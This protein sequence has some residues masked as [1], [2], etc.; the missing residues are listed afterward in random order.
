MGMPIAS[1][2]KGM[3]TADTA[4]GQAAYVEIPVRFDFDSLAPR[5]SAAVNRLHTAAITDLG[6]AGV[7][8]GLIELIRLRASQ[9][10]GC[11]YCVDTHTVDART[12]G[13]DAQR[14]DL[15][16]VW[17][18]APVYTE[19]ERAALALTESVTRLSQ[20][21]VPEPVVTRALK[22]LGEAATAAILGLI[23][24]IN[25]WNEIGVTSRCWPVG[26]RAE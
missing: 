17:E 13:V 8:Q 3:T 25:A 14:V 15:L 4:A 10:N 9:L 11:A 7:E 26:P 12:A 18:D 6:N 19:R 2:R 16:P 1:Y 24:S 20:T 5:V 22:A 21:H 23:V